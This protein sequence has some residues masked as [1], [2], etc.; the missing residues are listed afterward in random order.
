M[1]YKAIL[2]YLEFEVVTQIRVQSEETITFPVVS[3]CNINPWASNESFYYIKNF[4]DKTYNQSILLYEQ[5]ARLEKSGVIDE[6]DS[7]W[8]WY[9]TF[10][11]E[12]DDSFRKQFGFEPIFHDCKFNSKACN[13]SEFEW[14]YS[15]DY[16]KRS[17]LKV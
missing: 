9:K 2:Q 5:I 1:V 14:W 17:I 6:K 7:Y 8:L 4:Y 13:L 15:P 3:F 10:D 11:P 12:Y 16:G